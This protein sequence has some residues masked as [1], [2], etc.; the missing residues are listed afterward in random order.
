MYPFCHVSVS[1]TVGPETACAGAGA[2][3]E[4]SQRT[5]PGVFPSSVMNKVIWPL[6][7]GGRFLIEPLAFE[8]LYTPIK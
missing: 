7:A 5:I 1:E 8:D 4:V 2:R 6:V 3:A